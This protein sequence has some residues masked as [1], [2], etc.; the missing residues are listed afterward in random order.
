MKRRAVPTFRKSPSFAYKKGY[1]ARVQFKQ[2]RDQN[3]YRYQAR[4]GQLH[5]SSPFADEWREGWN[6]AD[7]DEANRDN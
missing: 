1:E 2:R 5:S 4:N 7:R 3:P 6:Q